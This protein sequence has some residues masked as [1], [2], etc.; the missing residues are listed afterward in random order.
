[1]SFERGESLLRRNPWTLLAGL[2][3]SAIALFSAYPRHAPPPPCGT[4]ESTHLV[5]PGNPAKFEI[6]ILPK[7]GG[8]IKLNIRD[9]GSTIYVDFGSNRENIEAP[10][11]NIPTE[12]DA[13]GLSF[14]SNKTHGIKLGLSQDQETGQIIASTTCLPLEDI[15]AGATKTWGSI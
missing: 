14:A 7:F 9:R 13:V 15:Y 5:T 12:P 6:P 3:C 11:S 8:I 1:M 10:K 2:G 4:S